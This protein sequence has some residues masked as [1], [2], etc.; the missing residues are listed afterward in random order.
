MRQ[1]GR[2]FLQIPGPSA[3]PDRILRA[4]DTPV[5]DHRGPGFA[6]IGNRVLTGIQSVFK[7]RQPVIIYPASGTGAWEAALVN[8]LSPGDKLLMV[9]TG[10]FAFLW[11]KLAEKLGLEPHVVETDWRRGA[12]PALIEEALKAD[13]KHS[14]KAVCVVHNETSTGATSQI[15][16]IRKAIDSLNHPAL[17]DGR[18]HLWPG[19]G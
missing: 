3:V 13:A 8:T 18:Y 15:A 6:D 11:Q 12:D 16:K 5:I 7:T 4:I 10:H 2:H 1:A 19:F 9:E 14:I 17:V